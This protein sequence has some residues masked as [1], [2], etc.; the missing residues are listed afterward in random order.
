MHALSRLAEIEDETATLGLSEI[1][2]HC[3]ERRRIIELA[4]VRWKLYNQDVPHTHGRYID[5][6][7]QAPETHTRF[8]A[9]AMRQQRDYESATREAATHALSRIARKGHP[10]V[11]QS[12]QWSLA[13]PYSRRASASMQ[14]L[15]CRALSDWAASPI[16]STCTQA[17]LKQLRNPDVHVHRTALFGMLGRLQ[18]GGLHK[19][20]KP[21]VGGGMRF[22]DVIK[23]LNSEAHVFAR[24]ASAADIK[25]TAS[26]H[27]TLSTASGVAIGQAET[28]SGAG[29]GHADAFARGASGVGTRGDRTDVSHLV[30]QTM[31]A[32]DVLTQGAAAVLHRLESTGSIRAGIRR[33]SSGAGPKKWGRLKAAVSSGEVHD[34]AMRSSAL[35]DLVVWHRSHLL[36]ILS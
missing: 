21:R 18:G 16:D 8:H 24:V 20:F 22:M 26:G 33:S 19:A 5:T 25:R 30:E 15:A 11:L 7:G 29:D 2:M 9:N 32:G 23:R 6:K 4:L 34:A 12:L 14:R 31:V 36:F 1:L 35:R 13:D 28:G 10:A 27:S 17:L 3:E